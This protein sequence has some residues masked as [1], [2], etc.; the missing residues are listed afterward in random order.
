MQESNRDCYFSHASSL[1]TRNINGDKEEISTT[2]WYMTCPDRNIDRQL[3]YK[4]ESRT[5]DVSEP[6]KEPLF[7]EKGYEC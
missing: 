7:R 3:V 5:H 6:D 2:T 4:E 1:I